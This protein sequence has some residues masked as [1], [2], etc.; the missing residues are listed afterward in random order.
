MREQLLY[1]LSLL[2]DYN[3]QEIAWLFLGG[4][5]GLCAIGFSV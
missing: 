4:L 1:G 2:A 3:N 5:I